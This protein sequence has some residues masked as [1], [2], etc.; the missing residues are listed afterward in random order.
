M[1]WLAHVGRAVGLDDVLLG[2]LPPGGARDL[3]RRLRRLRRAGLA[4]AAAAA[5]PRDAVRPTAFPGSEDAFWWDRLFAAIDGA[6]GELKTPLGR[7][8][9][10]TRGEHRRALPALREHV[11]TLPHDGAMAL[12]D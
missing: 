3:R 6:R 10:R 9:L 8:R 7:V 1:R 2:A 5:R 4:R 12:V 11:K